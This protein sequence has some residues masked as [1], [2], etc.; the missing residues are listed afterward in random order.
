M[1]SRAL[2]SS[3]RHTSSTVP[4]RPFPRCSLRYNEWRAIVRAQIAEV[5]RP[6]PSHH[7]PR[8]S[9]AP[10][11]GGI[12]IGNLPLQAAHTTVR[13][14]GT[15]DTRADNASLTDVSAHCVPPN[16]AI[17]GAPWRAHYIPLAAVPNH[18]AKSADQRSP[19]ATAMRGRAPCAP[20]KW[21]DKI[22][23]IRA[24]ASCKEA[25]EHERGNAELQHDLPAPLPRNDYVAYGTL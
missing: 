15:A 11:V 1:T 2:T 25:C 4:T 13:S 8:R 10:A 24:R 20:D 14:G 9:I 3:A 19:P 5:R 16:H 23:L 18:L 17:P 12:P 7:S 6:F 22:L 21:V